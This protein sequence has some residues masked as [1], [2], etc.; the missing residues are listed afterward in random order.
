M[1]VKSLFPTPLIVTEIEAASPLIASLRATILA[2]STSDAGS[3]RSN[4]GGWQSNDDLLDWTGED[5]TNLFAGIRSILDSSTATLDQGALKKQPLDWKFQAWANINRLGHGNAVH[6]HPASYWS[7][8][9]YVDD[10]GIA[11]GQD[12]GGAIEFKDPRGAAPLMYAPGVKMTF[13]GCLSAG[14]SERIYP[15]TG[16]LLLFP[17]WLAHSVMPYGGSGTR[18]SIAFNC[19][20][21]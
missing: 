19:S 2:R 6:F 15:K 18:I 3:S 10:G 8:S 7:G 14:L 17:S 11:G 16:Q 1:I 9:F 20:L 21:W 5:G 13:D 4:E 12:L